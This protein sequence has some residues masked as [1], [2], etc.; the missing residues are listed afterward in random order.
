CPMDETLKNQYKAEVK[1]LRAYYLF[2][3]AFY[4][5]D[6][7]MP[8]KTLSV[9]E[10]NTIAQTPQQQVYDQVESDLKEAISLLPATY[11]TSDVG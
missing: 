6:V 10:A 7:P 2:S 11:E 4:Y 5:K 3:L 9:A 8:L 1:C